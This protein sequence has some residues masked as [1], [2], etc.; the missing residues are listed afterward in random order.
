MSLAK[1]GEIAS[2]IGTGSGENTG[3]YLTWEDSMS[4]L[5]SFFR[6]ETLDTWKEMK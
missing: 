4:Q 1:V 5:N 3:D 6:T 2:M